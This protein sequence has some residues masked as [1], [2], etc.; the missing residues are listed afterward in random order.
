MMAL[1][2]ATRWSQKHTVQYFTIGIRILIMITELLANIF[3][4]IADGGDHQISLDM[5]FGMH[6]RLQLFK[7]LKRLCNPVN[8]SI[9]WCRN[10]IKRSCAIQWCYKCAN[11]QLNRIIDISSIS[12]R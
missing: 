1:P 8:H 4:S 10:V 3:K 2:F 5:K 11:E 9:L 6:I 7:I 12:S